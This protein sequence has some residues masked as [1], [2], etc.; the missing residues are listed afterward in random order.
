MMIEKGCKMNNIIVGKNIKKTCR[1]CK[2]KILLVCNNKLKRFTFTS[3]FSSKEECHYAAETVSN[4]KHS[5][6]YL[7]YLP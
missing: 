2:N 7:I 4:T 6:K 1:S 5:E 3:I